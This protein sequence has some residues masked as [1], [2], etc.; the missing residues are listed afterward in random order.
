MVPMAQMSKKNIA[1]PIGIDYD[2]N[3]PLSINDLDRSKVGLNCNLYCPNVQCGSKLK[4]V[5]SKTGKKVDFLS[6]VNKVASLACAE[7]ALHLQGKMA[8]TKLSQFMTSTYELITPSTAI[9]FLGISHAILGK[10][11]FGHRPIIFICPPSLEQ[12]IKEDVEIKGDVVVSC[13][14][15]KHIL[16]INFEIKVTHAVDEDKLSKIQQLDITT[17]EIDISHLIGLGVLEDMVVLEAITDPANHTLLH[18]NS[19]LETTY[20]NAVIDST[21]Q[22]I[23]RTNGTI[24]KR[25]EELEE[26]WLSN[27][28]E[29][30]QYSYKLTKLP[31]NIKEASLILG[32]SMPKLPALVTVHSFKH[33]ED[34]RLSLS[35]T[36]DGKSI[37]IPL[38]IRHKEDDLK[39]IKLA[40]ESFLYFDI[41]SLV[42]HSLPAF[43]YWGFNAKAHRYQQ[44]YNRQAD[45]EI[46]DYQQK[47]LTIADDKK[48]KVLGILS[49][50]RRREYQLYQGEY[51]HSPNEDMIKHKAIDLLGKLKNMNVSQD[52]IN[53]LH[54]PNVDP[55]KI[56]GVMPNIWQVHLCYHGT[57]EGSLNE[58]PKAIKYLERNG[59]K[60]VEP[61][62]TA[63]I[64]N[65]LFKEVGLKLPFKN[66]YSVISDYRNKKRAQL[67]QLYSQMAGD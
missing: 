3:K 25:I 13:K 61:Y 45:I 1:V 32:V 67:K 40:K 23:D 27:K 16:D 51:F 50:I 41:S 49:D 56:F 19:K 58:I 43:V 34:N 53:A 57:L 54:C 52:T 47:K 46:I 4:A 48:R 37:K 10:F 31:H 28:L 22:F 21:K 66:P 6:H 35:I 64:N 60:I 63:L 18:V 9:D 55:D 2:T 24:T 39:Q 5:F 42:G 14:Y 62:K 7:S 36:L 20:K 26:K 29:L 38:Y 30:P 33:I 65:P 11:L 12:T 17:I 59:I 44:E 8:F 15:D